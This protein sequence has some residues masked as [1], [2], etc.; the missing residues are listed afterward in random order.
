M[1]DLEERL[2]K[3]D[4]WFEFSD[5]RQVWK[6]GRDEREFLIADLKELPFEQAL[7]LV[8]K[9]VPFECGQQYF[10]ELL[11]ERKFA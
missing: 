3:A 11:P 6:R 1:N 8:Y 2:K 7:M 9:H 4:H 5:D 10:R